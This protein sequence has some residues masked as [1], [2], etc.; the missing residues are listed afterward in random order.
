MYWGNANVDV[1]WKLALLII[2]LIVGFVVALI[3]LLVHFTAMQSYCTHIAKQLQIIQQ[4]SRTP[5]GERI[6]NR[7]LYIMHI[8]CD[9]YVVVLRLIKHVYLARE[10]S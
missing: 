1:D 5:Q 10:L 9:A 7:A 2:F 3:L 4:S 8:F 6:F